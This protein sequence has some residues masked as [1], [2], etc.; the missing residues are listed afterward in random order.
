M[1]SIER[2]DVLL[3]VDGQLI[4]SLRADVI[5][6]VARCDRPFV[7][8]SP[9]SRKEQKVERP[10]LSLSPSS[11]V[12]ETSSGVNRDSDS[13]VRISDGTAGTKIGN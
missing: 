7:P 11:R 1:M 10:P 12:I 8:N 4:N 3:L 6:L 13:F 9:P 2:Y 5:N